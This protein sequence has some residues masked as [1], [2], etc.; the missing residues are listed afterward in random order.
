MSQGHATYVMSRDKYMSRGHENIISLSVG[1][2]MYRDF[3]TE[4]KGIGMSQGHGMH[5]MNRD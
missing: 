5:G 2:M 3:D 1:A 4:C